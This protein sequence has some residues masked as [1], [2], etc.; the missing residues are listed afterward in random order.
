MEDVSNVEKLES[1][2]SLQSTIK[3]LEN[4]LSQMTQNAV[5]TT[6]VKKRLNAVYIG[7][8]ILENVWNQKPHQ[9]THEDLAEARKVIIGLTPSV[10]NSYAKSKTGS[11]Q[12]TLLER[13]LKALKLVVQAI[14]EL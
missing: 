11:P 14:G 2:R 3:K 8:A 13:R 1:I 7:L 10:E 5:N 12:R 4:A 9:Y 6:L